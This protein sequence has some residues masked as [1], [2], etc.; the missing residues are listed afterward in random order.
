[1]GINHCI[2]VANGTDALE[3]ALRVCGVGPGDEVLT[4]SHTAV[5]TAAAVERCGAKP[6]LIDIDPATYTMDPDSLKKAIQKTRRPKA[7]IPVHLY[8]NPADMVSITKIAKE[9]EL[10]IIEDASQ[11]H[12]ASI[13]GRKVGTWGDLA[14]FSFYPTKNLGALGDGGAVVTNDPSLA[15]KV[16]SIREYGWK[17]RYVSETPGL[18]SRLDELQAAVLRVKLRYLGEENEA[19]YEKAQLYKDLL[20]K[21][22][23]ILPQTKTGMTHVYHQYVIRTP[24][25][26]LSPRRGER[27]GVR[28]RD[29]LKFFLEAHSIKTAI[30]ILFPFISSLPIKEGYR[31]EKAGLK[32][33]NSLRAKS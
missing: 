33:Q 4:V 17:E 15:D 28:G 7:V 30:H 22:S 2:G 11:A 8:G 31:L 29:D 14:A 23:L 6:V 10:R 9:K 1:M 24:H 12:G 13:N 16:R 32:I 20:S 25:P 5:A 3:V 18:N 21:T 19:R 27:V 26:S